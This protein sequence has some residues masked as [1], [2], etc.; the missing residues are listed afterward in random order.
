[1]NQHKNDA[2]HQ[3]EDRHAADAERDAAP[4]LLAF[5]V[6]G[7]V[8][9]A[10]GGENAE[11]DVRRS[12]G[13]AGQDEN[14]AED[15]E[16]VDGGFRVAVFSP[17]ARSRRRCIMGRRVIACAPVRKTFVT[18]SLYLSSRPILDAIPGLSHDPCG[19]TSRGAGRLG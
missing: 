8:E 1:M 10:G 3:R 5:E 14:Q 11:D 18:S 12:G 4:G 15:E 7:G 17:A 2:H 13:T 16:G 19:S 6:G 9:Q